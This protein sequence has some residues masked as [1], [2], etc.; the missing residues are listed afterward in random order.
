[1]DFESGNLGIGGNQHSAAGLVFRGSLGK[2]FVD[3][4][5]AR[6]SRLNLSGWVSGD[7]ERIAVWVKG[8]TALIDAFEI[9]C[10]LGPIDSTVVQ[11]T[12]QEGPMPSVS[13]SGEARVM[14]G[15]SN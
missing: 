12:R 7:G 13:A 5:F 6:A 1:M 2:P 15:F 8:P 4:V 14:F 11:W 3:F 9:A 10:S